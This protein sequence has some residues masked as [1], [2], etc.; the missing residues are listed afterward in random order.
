MKHLKRNRLLTAIQACLILF[1]THTYTKKEQFTPQ[2]FNLN[3]TPVSTKQLNEHQQLYRGYVAKRNEIN[4]KLNTIE[5]KGNASFS[6]FRSLKIGETFARN[7]SLLH[8]LY[9]ANIGKQTK[10]QPQT[11]K[12]LKKHFGSLKKFKKDLFACGLSSRG[13][14]VTAY[15][16]DDKTISNYILDAHNQTVPVL[17]IPLLVLDVYEHA[18]MIDFG[19]QRKQYLQTFWKTI[20]WDI[21][22][23]RIKQWMPA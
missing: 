8:E 15:N 13:W 2:A 16:L 1:C 5:K 12:L 17:T 21:V 4:N 14:V 7:G 6:E 11:K 23:Q 9:F 3:N 19:I 20:N 18:Y 10:P 22:E